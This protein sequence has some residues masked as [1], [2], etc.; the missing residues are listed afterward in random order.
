MVGLAGMSP[1][2]RTTGCAARPSGG[3]GFCEDHQARYEV[4]QAL[5][6]SLVET[7]RC[8]LSWDRLAMGLTEDE[9]EVAARCIVQCTAA[10]LLG[11]E[12]LR[13]A[14]PCGLAPTFACREAA[15][16]YFRDLDDR[17]LQAL[18]LQVFDDRWP[19]RAGSPRLAVLPREG[20][21]E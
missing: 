10:G 16:A 6:A 2:C 9:A 19:V 7:V 15:L 5:L 4:R 13:L 17:L 8:R 12:Q 3:L 21:G 20:G 14:M 18:G 1:V 11:R